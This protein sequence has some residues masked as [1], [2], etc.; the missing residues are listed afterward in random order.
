MRNGTVGDFDGLLVD[1]FGQ[2]EADGLARVK[3]PG[4]QVCEGVPDAAC[5][6]ERA[7]RPC[8]IRDRGDSEAEGDLS[9]GVPSR[10]GRGTSVNNSFGQTIC[11]TTI[12]GDSFD[13]I[14]DIATSER[15]GISTRRYCNASLAGGS[16]QC[17]P[18]GLRQ[19]HAQRVEPGKY[20]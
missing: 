6:G 7:V 5:A 18:V 17:F 1:G 12:D 13:S 8:Q 20:R 16:Q 9:L 4:G 19:N 15:A 10:S 14:A 2:V 11:Y 3:L